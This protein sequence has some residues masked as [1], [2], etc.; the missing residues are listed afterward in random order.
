MKISNVIKYLFVLLPVVGLAQ[1]PT[2]EK[3]A[4]FM[5]GRSG[6]NVIKL[7][8]APNNFAL[9]QACIKEG[10]VLERY[11]MKRVGELRPPSERQKVVYPTQN[12]ILP[13]QDQTTWAAM[14]DTSDYAAVAAQA[15]FGSSFELSNSA[16]TADNLSAL[17]NRA[18]EQQNRF[19]FAMFVADQSFELAK[20]MG[21]GFEDR[22]IGSNA[23]YLYRVYPAAEIAPAVDTAYFLVST[24]EPYLLPKVTELK[25]EFKNRQAI[26][27]WNKGRSQTFYSD[28]IVERSEDG[29]TYQSIHAKPFVG[30]EQDPSLDAEYALRLDELPANNVPYFYRVRGR[31]IFGELGPASDPVQGMGIDPLPTVFPEVSEILANDQGGLVLAWTFAPDANEK[32]AG[33]KVLRSSRAKGTY[34]VI[35][36]DQL[37][38]AT[39]RSFVDELPMPTNYYKVEAWDAYGRKI[40]SFEALGQVED[41][42][43]PAPPQDIRGKVMPDGKMVLTWKKNTE[44]DLAGY[45]VYLSNNPTTEFAQTTSAV[46]PRNYFVDSVSLNTLSEKIYIKLRA[47]DLRQNRSEFSEVAVVLRPDTIPPS[48]PVFKDV[49]ASDQMVTLAWAYSSS[50]DIQQHELLRRPIDEGGNWETIHTVGYL[51]S[52]SLGS[53]QDSLAEKGMQYHYRLVAVDDNEHRT[54]SKIVRSG[55]IDNGIRHGVSDVEVY[56]D[57][58]AKTIDLTW[59]YKAGRGF[60]HFEIYRAQNDEN[61]RVYQIAKAEEVFAQLHRRSGL[62]LY[63]FTDGNLRMQTGYTYRIRAVYENGAQSP[64]SKAAV[65]QY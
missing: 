11:T 6:T 9:W 57:R 50:P 44:P 60:R 33:F 15:M 7:R 43:P 22:N 65:I 8:W 30:L 29:L 21:L 59:R 45:R 61:P 58:R 41:S 39:A 42:T 38:P 47:I 31:T 63:Q 5:L 26:I 62:S 64:L 19:S 1:S 28:Y 40:S 18:E 53:F 24:D 55:I 13:E 48:A 4:L 49:V 56:A 36:G 14:A 25:A 23:Q 37:M 35:S 52:G 17:I 27:T 32:I 20:A 16:V 54:A 2:V 10:V 51:D 12:P 46:V 34:S 3:D